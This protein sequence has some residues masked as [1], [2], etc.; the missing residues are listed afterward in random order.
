MNKGFGNPYDIEF[1]E[2]GG[3]CKE[4]ILQPYRTRNYKRGKAELGTL[5]AGN[6]F[7]EIGYVQEILPRYSVCLKIR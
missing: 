6:H 3:E 7:I 5:G 4:T 2:E 1:S